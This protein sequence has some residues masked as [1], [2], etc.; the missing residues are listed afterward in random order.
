MH[1][2]LGLVGLCVALAA[3]LPASASAAT[4][5]GGFW[6]L[7]EN[8]GTTAGDSSGNANNGTVV[9]ATRISGRFGRS[10]HFDGIDD[11]VVVPRSSTLEPANVTVESWL[12]APASPGPYKHIIS[13]GASDCGSASYGL[14]TGANGGLIFYIAAT[15][16]TFALSPDAGAAIWD[17]NW[18]HVAGTFDGATVRL[19]VDGVEVGGGTPTALAI[20]Y[21][22]NI[23]DGFLGGFGTDCISPI[24]NQNLNYAGDIDEPRIWRRAMA[25]QEIVASA[26]MNDPAA[27]TLG[28]SIS[29]SQALVFTSDFSSANNIKI[30]IE[31]ATG[32]E[33][34][35]SIRLQGVLPGILGLASCRNDL[36]GLLFSNCDITL[37]NDGRTAAVTVR[38]LNVLTSG[39][40]LRVRVTS[41]RTFDV[42]VDT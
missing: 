16:P 18:H 15:S 22:F 40:T 17:G 5:L 30:S 3:A 13:Q 41:G 19:Y 11:K 33:R 36:L 42:D 2:R 6:H 27:T 25:A 38:K 7:N 8:T 34:I 37:S 32:S 35:S 29:S 14:Y 10:L 12:R 23:P 20:G 26:A 24:T 9:G 31:S 39:A 4:N 1:L 21:P 28:Q